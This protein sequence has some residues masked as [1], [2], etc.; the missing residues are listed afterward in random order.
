MDDRLISD[1]VK[2]I[3]VSGIRKFFNKVN[4]YQDAISLTLGQPDFKL[5]KEIK[6]GLIHA[7]NND[8][9]GYTSNIGINELREEISVYLK[10]INI[11]YNKDEICLTVGG[12][13]ALFDV[14]TT[15][16]NPFDKVL[17]PTPA[18]PAYESCTKL[19]G[20]IPINY[21]LNA[22]FLLD[23][24]KIEMLIKKEKPKVLV[25]SFPT[26][27]TGAVMIKEDRDKLYEIIKR[28]NILVITDE[29]YSSLCFDKDYYS[30]SQFKDIKEKV[31]LIGGFSKMFSMTGLRIG[32]LCAED[33]YMKHIIKVHQYNTSCAPSIVQ[34]GAL[35]GLKYCMEDVEYMKKQ[36]I[37]RRNYAYERL[38]NLG[39]QVNFPKGAFYIFPSINKYN[40]SSERFCNRLL[41]EGKVAVVPGSAFGRA[42]EGYI[43]ISYA[44]SYEE[45]KE[46]FN[47]I[48][49]WLK[50]I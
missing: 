26:N 32:Y 15:V 11:D 6:E 23:I 27:P 17:I 36:F 34:W 4:K 19:L 13:E 38:T 30:I 16:L 3:E 29:I 5:P 9:T 10:T 43:R 8:K 37:K 48:E 28:N 22:E 40:M 1:Y 7:I 49:K 14:F 12:S 31:I 45:L 25:I 18:Y 41:E 42:G 24:D 50:T 44:Y 35:Y 47:R 21:T 46:A 20:A 39:F 2:N 33:K